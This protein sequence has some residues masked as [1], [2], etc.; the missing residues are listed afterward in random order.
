MNKP[1]MAAEYAQQVKARYDVVWW[2]SNRQGGSIRTALA[3]RNDLELGEQG[4]RY[5]KAGRMP[6]RLA[7][8]PPY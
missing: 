3:P 6:G 4:L 2:V 5:P 7:Q 8:S 1:Q